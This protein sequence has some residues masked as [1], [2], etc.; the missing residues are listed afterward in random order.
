MRTKLRLEA[1]YKVPSGEKVQHSQGE[2]C[3]ILPKI[4]T[5]P[6]SDDVTVK[7]HAAKPESGILFREWNFLFIRAGKVQG[8]VT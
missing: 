6:I 5:S 3:G 2:S 1:V 8:G 4:L 7:Q